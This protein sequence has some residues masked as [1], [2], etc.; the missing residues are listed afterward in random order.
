MMHKK[1]AGVT[2]GLIVGMLLVIGGCS[3]ESAPTGGS[4]TILLEMPKSIVAA[5][6]P[7]QTATLD[8][9]YTE[10]FLGFPLETAIP[11]TVNADGSVSVTVSVFTGTWQFRIKYYTAS[12]MKILEAIGTGTVETGKATTISTNVLYLSLIHI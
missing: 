6:L 4:G 11:M 10:G 12:E 5:A 3:S 1:R 2:V 7:G 9:E 8:I